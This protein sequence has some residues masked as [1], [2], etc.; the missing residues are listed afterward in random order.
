MASVNP[1][2]QNM[3]QVFTVF[4]LQDDLF[5]SKFFSLYFLNTSISS[6][7][8]VIRWKFMV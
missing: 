2:I 4:D 1:I 6:Y 5:L 3:M 8:T 7:I